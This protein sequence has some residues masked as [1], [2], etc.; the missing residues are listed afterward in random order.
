MYGSGWIRITCSSHNFGNADVL[1]RPECVTMHNGSFKFV[2]LKMVYAIRV[3]SSPS[4]YL[5]QFEKLKDAH[6]SGLSKSAIS[7]LKLYKND[8]RNW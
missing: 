5:Y 2:I 1:L 4:I 6:G 8:I 3:N 7:L